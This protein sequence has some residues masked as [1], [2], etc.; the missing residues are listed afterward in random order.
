[1]LFEGVFPSSKKTYM[2]SIQNFCCLMALSVHDYLIT[3][4]PGHVGTV[5]SQDPFQILSFLELCSAQSKASFQYAFCTLSP[6][7]DLQTTI[8]RALQSMASAALSIFPYWYKGELTFDSSSP[9]SISGQLAS[10]ANSHIC[11]QVGLSFR[12]LQSAVNRCLGNH[13]PLPRKCSHEIQSSQLSLAIGRDRLCLGLFVDDS[14]YEPERLLGLTKAAEWLARVSQARVLVILP[15]ALSECD[16]CQRI[17]YKSLSFNPYQEQAAPSDQP[18][19]EHKYTIWP[20]QGFAHPF[21]PGEQIL[22]EYLSRDSSL[23][24][25]FSFNQPVLTVRNTRFLV[26][27]LWGEGKIIVEVDG[28]KTHSSR[29]AFH[30]DRNRDYELMISGYLVLRLPHDEVVRDPE[31][32][33]DKIRDL[34]A[35]RTRK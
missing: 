28:F 27:L 6:L 11:N 19:E 24:P 5:F 7:P 31:M 10:P 30:Q 33:L 3:I 22:A 8:N 12:W 35:F 14:S 15:E 13:L 32:A 25:L 29:L 2:Q 16:E 18:T 20:L 21:S 17:A 4:T 1:M 9:H 26:D 23:A 34:V